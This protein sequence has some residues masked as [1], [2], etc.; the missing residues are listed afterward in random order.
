MTTW[1]LAAVMVSAMA[2]RSAAATPVR[3]RVTDPDGLSLPGVIVTLQSIPAGS[4]MTIMTDQSGLFAVEVPPGRYRLTADL[5]GLG[6]VLRELVV[7][8][9]ALVLDLS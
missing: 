1:F 3:G 9:E 4:T 8:D 2:P 5:S 7:R 6:R